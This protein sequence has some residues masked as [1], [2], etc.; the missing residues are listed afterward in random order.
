MQVNIR[1]VSFLETKFEYVILETVERER[2]RESVDMTS[3]LLYIFFVFV[4]PKSVEMGNLKGSQQCSMALFNWYH[5]LT[6]NLWEPAK[7]PGLQI[8]HAWP[9]FHS[10][11]HYSSCSFI[12]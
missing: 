3:F 9:W 11:V 7:E 10:W 1:S 12:T 8:G 2:E 4:S 5:I 6:G